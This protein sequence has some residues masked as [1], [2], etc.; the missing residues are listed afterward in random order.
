VCVCVCVLKSE[1]NGDN[2]HCLKIIK[3]KE[4]QCGSGP[5]NKVRI[6]LTQMKVLTVQ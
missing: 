3:E 4:K 5:R 1:R 6:W 2:L